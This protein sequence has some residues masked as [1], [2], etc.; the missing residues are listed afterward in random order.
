MSRLVSFLEMLR[1][2]LE[3]P[4]GRADFAVR[5][6]KRGHYTAARMAERGDLAGLLLLAMAWG[7]DVSFFSSN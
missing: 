7:G 5:L 2:R 4:I 6:A 3:H 1:F